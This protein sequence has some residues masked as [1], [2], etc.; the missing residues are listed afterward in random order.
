MDII[1][2]KLYITDDVD[3]KFYSSQEI[4]LARAIC[5]AHSDY[6]VDI[7]LLSR[8]VEARERYEVSDRIAVHTLPGKG[9]GHHGFLNLDILKELEADHVHLLA[10]N[11]VYAPNVIRYCLENGIGCHLYIGTILSDS[12]KWY[13]Q[14][15]NRVLIGRNIRAYK[16]IPVYVKTPNVQEQCRSLGIEAKLAPVGLPMEA[17]VE[18]ERDS[19]DI[20]DEF[21]LPR[22]KKILLFVGRLEGYKHPLDAVEVLRKLRDEDVTGRIAEVNDKHSDAMNDEHLTGYHLCIVGK[23][24]MQQELEDRIVEYGLSDSVSLLPKVPNTQ[25]KDLFHACDYYVN[26]NPDEI[27]GMAIL[28]AMCHECLVL[29]VKAPGPEFLVEDGVTGF[30]CR[31]ADEMAEKIR[32]M[33]GSDSDGSGVPFDQE[34]ARALARRRVLDKFTWQKTVECFDCF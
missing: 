25:M 2:L 6:R 23:G 31:D 34:Q 20:R 28:E 19:G 22:D 1:F 26:F 10:D 4:G 33:D 7:V 16:K 13:K 14:L 18:S 15:A 27:Y 5:E 3:N 21:L 30:I 29:A 17:T 24:E 8:S 11:M 9:I 12:S 32:I